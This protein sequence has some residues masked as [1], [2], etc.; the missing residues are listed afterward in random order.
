MKCV[1]NIGDVVDDEECNMKFWLN[2]I[3][4]CDM[5]FCVKSWFFIEWSE[6]CLVECGVGVWICLVVCMI[7]YVSSLFLEGCGN[8]WLVEVILCD[9]GFCMGK[10]EWFVGSWS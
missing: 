6:R 10:V 3:E 5:G 4:N 2:D 8:N 7:N 9:N 1:S